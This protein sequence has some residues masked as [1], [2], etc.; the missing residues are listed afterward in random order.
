MIILKNVTY[1]YADSGKG[2]K[3]INLKIKRGEVIGIIG[4]NG[5]GKT[6]LF[7]VIAGLLK[8]KGKITIDGIEMN[9]K[10]FYKL[11]KKI[12]LLFQEPDDQL[13]LPAVYEN[14]EYGIKDLREEVKKERIREVEK[15][16]HLEEIMDRMAHHLSVG[17]KKKVALATIF[18]MKPE[19]YLLDEPTS[20]LDPKT[21]KEIMGYINKLPGIKLI[22][23]H[24]IDMIKKLCRRIIV[25]YN[26]EII[27]DNKKEF[28]TRKILKKAELV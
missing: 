22:A 17:E 20:S 3:N 15:F 13:F 16:F 24:D 25:L 5:A 10:S 7:H 2:I 23:S 14:I 18:V 6:T 21:R 28:L 9:K 27:F 1:F 12:G 8:F 11:R 4:T 19:I 26:G